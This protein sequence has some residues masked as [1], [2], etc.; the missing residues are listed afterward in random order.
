MLPWTPDARETNRF[1]LILSLLMV[2]F[3]SMALVIPNVDL[4]EKD[5]K[6]L[7]K[8]PPQ[9]AKV[10]LKKKIEKKKIEKKKE[11]PPK[12][13]KEKPKEKKKRSLSQKSKKHRPR[14]SLKKP[15]KWLKIQACW[16]F[17]MT[18]L[19]CVHH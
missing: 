13:K 17:R 15:G 14:Q 9:L 18:W 1:W 12:P 11:E 7:E 19:I 10:I 5:R 8:L 4:P 3:L 16:R 2:V 6:Q